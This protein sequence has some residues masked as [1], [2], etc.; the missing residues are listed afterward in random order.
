M[1]I[2]S[3]SADVGGKGNVPNGLLEERHKLNPEKSVRL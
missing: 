3:C 2:R 1:G